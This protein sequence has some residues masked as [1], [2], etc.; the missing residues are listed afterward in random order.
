MLAMFRAAIKEG[1]PSGSTRSC[2]LAMGLE[3]VAHGIIVIPNL[4]QTGGQLILRHVV[5]KPAALPDHR[6]PA[7][8]SR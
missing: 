8:A 1:A 3:L 2:Q 5:I 4:L 7:A 6:T